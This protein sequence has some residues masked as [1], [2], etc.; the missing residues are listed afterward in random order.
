MASGSGRELFEPWPRRQ[1]ASSS[2]TVHPKLA[3]LLVYLAA[4]LPFACFAVGTGSAQTQTYT[5]SVI[6]NFCGQGANCSDGA[7]PNEIIQGSD[8]SFYGTTMAGGSGLVSANVC[9][10]ALFVGT[11]GTVFKIATSGALTTL[12]NFCTQGGANC[13][14]GFNPRSNLVEGSDGDFYGT[15]SAGGSGNAANCVVPG[16]PSYF[17]GCGT[18]FKITPTGGLTTLHSFCTQ[19]GASCSDGFNPVANLVEGPDG[20][21]YG[22]TA[23][24]GANGEGTVFKITPSGGLETLYSFCSQS[25]GNS[26]VATNCVDGAVPVTGLVP[27]GNGNFYGGTNGGGALSLGGRFGTIF[28]ISP[29]GTLDTLYSFCTPDCSTGFDPMDLIEGKDGAVYGV[30]V[31]GNFELNNAVQAGTMFALTPAGAFSL[32]YSF[33]TVG[34]CLDG[35]EPVVVIEGADGNFYG[36]TFLGGS[37]VGSISQGAGTAFKLNPSGALTTIY[38]FCSQGGVNCTDGALPVGLVQA[39]D[40]NF[41]GT[42]QGGGANNG[43]TVFKLAPPG[44]LT[45][46]AISPDG[47]VSASAYGKFAT[48][49]PGSQ[50]EI[51]GSNLAKDTRGWDSADFNGVNAPTSLEGTSVTIDG[52]NAFVDYIS[53]D[54]VNVVVPSDVPTGLQPL[55][56]KTD[57]GVSPTLNVIVNALEP[58]LLAP[59]SFNLKGT[60]FVVAFLTDG[61]YALQSGAI[62]GLNSRPAHRATSSLSTAWVSGRSCL[63]YRPASW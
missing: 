21:F 51:Y 40:G 28:E 10:V 9:N 48:I 23:Y 41:Y 26:A 8:G 19:G 12:Y 42:T 24:G 35:E 44:S 61:A 62:A 18:I 15:T 4:V 16:P 37:E 11:C 30:T 52:K 32:L 13:T 45:S 31:N 63:T 57:A 59:P 7:L 17:G 20:N 49:A 55:M 2:R 46:P 50:I 1:T 38:D 34:N 58:G 5:E 14:D 25:T 43:G 29:S 3:K 39:S 47:V 53:P 56:V 36:I 6:Y 60:Q 33:C 22:T 54:Q 27:D